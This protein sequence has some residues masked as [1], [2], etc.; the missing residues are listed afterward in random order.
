MNKIINSQSPKRYQSQRFRISNLL[1][2][3]PRWYFPRESFDWKRKKNHL[4]FWA[5]I[6]FSHCTRSWS[7]KNDAGKPKF[8]PK[9]DVYSY[10]RIDPWEKK[11]ERKKKEEGTFSLGYRYYPTCCDFGS[12]FF[13]S[14]SEGFVKKGDRAREGENRGQEKRT[15]PGAFIT[16]VTRNRTMRCAFVAAKP[17]WG[18]S[19][20]ARNLTPLL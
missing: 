13:F 10:D 15:L 14:D 1:I 9:F 11:S 4:P 16:S 5:L 8:C 19:L 3:S 20:F 2:S 12:S 17:I 7:K 6:L 18:L